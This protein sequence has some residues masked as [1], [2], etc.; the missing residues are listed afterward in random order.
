V[1][2]R[3]IPTHNST[4]KTNRSPIIHHAITWALYADGPEKP[5]VSS[6]HVDVGYE[7]RLIVVSVGSML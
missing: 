6:A 7:H 3:G 2:V 1:F 4:H 5:H